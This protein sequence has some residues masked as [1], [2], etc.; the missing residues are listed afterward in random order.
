MVIQIATDLDAGIS[1]AD[2]QHALSFEALGVEVLLRVKDLSP[3]VVLS[4]QLWNEWGH[5]CDSGRKHDLICG[6]AKKFRFALPLDLRLPT[7]RRV[8]T[9]MSDPV[10]QA[11][12]EVVQSGVGL[13][14]LG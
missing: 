6:K 5:T 12:V 2:D 13:Q 1:R 14:V 10:L 4:F 11:H 3:P 9:Q 7:S 8:S